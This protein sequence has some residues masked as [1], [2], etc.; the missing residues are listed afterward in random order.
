MITKGGLAMRKSRKYIITGGVVAGLLVGGAA[1]AYWTTDGSGTGTGSTTSGVAS[2]VTINQG[3]LAAM[4]PGDSAQDIVL[5]ATNNEPAGGQSAHVT[6]VSGVLSVTGSGTCDPTDFQV[7]GTQLPSSGAFTTAWSPVEVA[8][9]TTSDEQHV[10]N[11][12]FFNKTSEQDGCKSAAVS[13]VYT[14]H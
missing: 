7:D 3:E 9:H 13:I 10:A 8:A 14:S 1:F 11:I 2:A 4:Y 12:H 5:T 6:S